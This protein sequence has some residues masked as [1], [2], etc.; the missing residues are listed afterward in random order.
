M[1]QVDRVSAQ[2]PSLGFENL[3]R[4][5]AQATSREGR[6]RASRNL[7]VAELTPEQQ[8]QVDALRETDRKVRAHEQAHLST[9]GDLVEG[10]PSFTYSAGA[11]GKRYAVAGEVN[12]DVSPARTPEETILKALHIRAAALA[13]ADPSA[14]DRQVASLA[15]QMETQARQALATEGTQLQGESVALYRGVG[16]TAESDIGGRLNVFA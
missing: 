8:R 6:G 1:A 3:A 2:I 16:S 15:S 14:Q 9:G 4:F 10:G 12:I 11:D 13:P 7:G 5:G